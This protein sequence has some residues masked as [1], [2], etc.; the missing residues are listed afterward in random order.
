VIAGRV[1]TALGDD[2]ALVTVAAG[3]AIESVLLKVH[4]A[5]SAGRQSVLVMIDPDVAGISRAML[6][7]AIGPLAIA[8]APATRVNALDIAAGA[9][10][11][12]VIAAAAFLA[13]AGSTTGQVI[14]VGG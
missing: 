7:A 4:A 2:A 6:R 11:D 9:S 1:A 8:S 12:A 3:S 13:T 10:T 5:V 14:D